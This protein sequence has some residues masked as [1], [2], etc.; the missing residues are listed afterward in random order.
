MAVGAMEERKNIL[1][2]DDDEQI[3]FVWR[4]A[5]EGHSRHWRV[6]TAQT[7]HEALEKIRTANFDLIVTDIRIPGGVDGCDL[8]VAVRHLLGDVPVIWITAY[9]Q[10]GALAKSE[11]LAVRRFLNKPIGVAQ[12]RQ[13]VA[14]VL[15]GPH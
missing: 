11:A 8:T 5:L 2:V 13:I 14:Q 10:P 7:G 1:V 15:E 6:E 3:L 9:P 12:I 4:G